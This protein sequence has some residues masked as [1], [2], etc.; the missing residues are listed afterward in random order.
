MTFLDDTWTHGTVASRVFRIIVGMYIIA[1]LAG[2]WRGSR[3]E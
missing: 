3:R 1:V 2:V